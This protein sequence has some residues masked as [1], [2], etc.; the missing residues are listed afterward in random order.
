MVF[1]SEYC[2]FINNFIL[3][4]KV[5]IFDHPKVT[6]MPECHKHWNFATVSLT[7]EYLDQNIKVI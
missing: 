2:S 5:N 7:L 3:K 1:C 4:F 6:N